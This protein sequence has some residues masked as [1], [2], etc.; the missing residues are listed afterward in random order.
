MPRDVGCPMCGKRFF[1][2]SLPIHLPQCE[3]KRDAQELPCPHCD[4][5]V[6]APDFRDHERKC[7]RRPQ[8]GFQ[9]PGERDAFSTVRTAG[10][11]GAYTKSSAVNAPYGARPTSSG[12][13]YARAAATLPARGVPAQGGLPV[14]G[15]TRFPEH[16][17]GSADA[18]SLAA[19]APFGD[20][21]G[22]DSRIRCGVC[23]RG[24]SADR[25]AIHQ[26]IC[27]KIAHKDR[28][29]FDVAAVRQARV[30]E[31]N[32]LGSSLPRRG[33]SRAGGARRGAG[34]VSPPRSALSPPRSALSPP[35]QN[36]WREQSN[37][38]Q[39]MVR[40]AR[41][42]KAAEQRGVPASRIQPSRAATSAY[43]SLQSD[44]VPCPHCGR[45]FSDQAAARHIPQCAN[46]INKPRAPPGVK[47]SPQAPRA[48]GR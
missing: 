25:V 33:A 45:T 30:A 14:R 12:G 3:K 6:R 40:D 13:G 2:H 7:K 22:G 42:M 19:S 11:G 36:R 26:R 17:R 34:A 37:A 24:F 10:S 29:V 8:A 38:F 43:A 35:R 32:G 18:R 5:L 16:V 46:I 15:A 41:R 47:R 44:F 39:A 1:K 48:F 9:R 27:R 28:R 23:G 21:G 20:S 31:A 4:A